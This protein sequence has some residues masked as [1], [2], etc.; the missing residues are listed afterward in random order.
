MIHINEILQIHF[1]VNFKLHFFLNIIFSDVGDSPTDQ[2]TED[3]DSE[4]YP[5]ED[6][7]DTFEATVQFDFNARSERELSLRKGE[8]VTLYNQ[9]IL[10]FF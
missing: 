8:A 1:P 4:V 5:S 2:V 6:E 3:P 7:S 9:V 10:S